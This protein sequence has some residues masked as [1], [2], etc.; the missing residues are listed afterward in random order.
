[1]TMVICMVKRAVVVVKGIIGAISSFPLL[2]QV[3]K[4]G[5]DIPRKRMDRD[6]SLTIKVID[7]NCGLRL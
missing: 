2:R 5:T 4:N 1:M 3:K 6:R 7:E